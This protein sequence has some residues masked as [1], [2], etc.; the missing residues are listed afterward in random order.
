MFGIYCSVKRKQ[1]DFPV[2]FVEMLS[3][4]GNYKIFSIDTFNVPHE[5]YGIAHQ[6]AR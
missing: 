5:R 1:N 2:E 4:D 6:R 3:L